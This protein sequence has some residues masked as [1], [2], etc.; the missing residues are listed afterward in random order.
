MSTTS[1]P[2]TPTQVLGPNETIDD[3]LKNNDIQQTMITPATP[4]AP[5]ID[6]PV[7]EGWKP[8]PDGPDAG[9]FGIEFKTPT[10]PNDPPK[11]V[12]TVREL[13]GDVDTDL[14]LAAAPRELKNL[15]GYA[16]SEAIVDT[17]SGYPASRLGGP[18]VQ[19]GVT[20]MVAQSTVVIDDEDGI[21]LLQINLVGPEPDGD[22]LKTAAAAI[23]EKTHDHT[24]TLATQRED[25]SA[26]NFE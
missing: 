13:T 9:Y 7:P 10:I 19:N 26:G 21:Y 2:A 18:V 22:A 17:L 24:M 12:A 11:I 6:I 3:Y 14:L 5:K 4:G 8:M 1:T 16:G 20:R 23:R 15:A 25:R